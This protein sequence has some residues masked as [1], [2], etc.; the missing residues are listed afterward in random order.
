MLSNPDTAI[1][2]LVRRGK[3]SNHST[4]AAN[5]GDFSTTDQSSIFATPAFLLPLIY[6]NCAGFAV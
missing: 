2:N 1:P 5:E 4:E 3:R 6:F